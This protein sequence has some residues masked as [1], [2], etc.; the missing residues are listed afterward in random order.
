MEASLREKALSIF[1]ACLKGADPKLCVKRFLK[2]ENGYISA[3]NFRRRLDQIKRI[4]VAGAGKASALMAQATEEILEDKIDKGIVV[5]EKGPEVALKKTELFFG[6]HPFPDENGARGTQEIL[7]MLSEDKDNDLVIFLLSGGGSALLVSSAEGVSLEDKKR[8][9]QLLFECG[10]NIDEMNTIRKHISKV[11]GGRLA[12]IA[13]PAQTISLIL[14]DVIGDRLDSI[15]SGPTSP[16][17]T[18]FEDCFEI[19]NRYKL[20]DK[21]P[22]SVRFFL[23]ENK[24]KQENETIKPGDEVFEKVEN[25]IVGS[26][27]LALKEAEKKAKKLD[28]NTLLLSS[29]VSG[30]TTRAA[31]EHA[32]LAREIINGREKISPPA[33]VISGGETTVE[34]KGNGKGGRNQEFVLASAIQIQGLKDMVISSINTDGI[35]GPTDAAGAICDGTTVSRAKK[36]S[37]DPEDHLKQNDSY[38]FFEKLGDLIK[39]GPTNTNVMDIHLILIG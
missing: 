3:G 7:Q 18:T 32:S 31:K 29:T 16:D 37:L 10:A 26:N 12:K 27:L 19:L 36:L 33:C 11:K 34:I 1:Q 28:F 6:G 14:S 2:L 39:T 8:M 38:H 4:I 35:D 25:I 23:E 24:G 21:I 20:L 13:Y 15:A 22:E 9:V 17:P 30:D 5:A